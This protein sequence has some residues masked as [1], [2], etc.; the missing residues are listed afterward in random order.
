MQILQANY[1]VKNCSS[2]AD[3]REDDKGKVETRQL[4]YLP[5]MS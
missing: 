2:D 1:G 3:V 4:E 5:T